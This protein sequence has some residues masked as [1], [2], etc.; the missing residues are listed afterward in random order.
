LFLQESSLHKWECAPQKLTASG[1]GWSHR[2]SEAAPFSGSRH[3]AT[4]PVRG[5]VSA[6]PRRALPQH[7]RKTSW[8]QDPA[9]VVCTGESVDYRS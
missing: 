1:T 2:A 3:P 5:Q 8:F 7:L 9:K 4:F 6:Q